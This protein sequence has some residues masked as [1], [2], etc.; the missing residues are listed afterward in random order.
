MGIIQRFG[1]KTAAL[2]NLMAY[3]SGQIDHA[4]FMR[5]DIALWQPTPHF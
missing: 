5:R 1:T 4:E 2:G 3:E